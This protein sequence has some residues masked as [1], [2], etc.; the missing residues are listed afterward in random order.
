MSTAG[1]L[2]RVVQL[3]LRLR[4]R[5]INFGSKRL[6]V[7]IAV[8]AFFYAALHGISFPLL[9]LLERGI[10]AAWEAA[11]WL[12]VAVLAFIAA[13]SGLRFQRDDSALLLT[14]PI[15]N[16]TVLWARL[17]SLAGASI[18]PTA[19][20]VTPSL[21]MAVLMHGPHYLGCYVVLACVATAS[22]TAAFS[23][24]LLLGRWLGPRRVLILVRVVG[25]LIA[26]GVVLLGQLPRLMQQSEL[27]QASSRVP[28]LNEWPLLAQ[29]TAA[30]RADALALLVVVAATTTVAW[31][32]AH[33]CG[34]ALARGIQALQENSARCTARKTLITYRWSASLAAVTYRKE[35]RLFVRDPVL[36][37]QSF[38]SIA[39]I[40]PLV[41]V[42]RN[43]G[44]GVLAT[45]ACA[46]AQLGSMPL[47]TTAAAAEQCWDVIRASPTPETRLRIAKLLA[48]VTLPVALA[49]V[50]CLALAVLGCPWLALTG[51]CAGVIGAAAAGWLQ[52]TDIVPHRRGVVRR[53]T[54]DARLL[55]VLTS[56]ALAAPLIG[57]VAACAQNHLLLGGALIGVGVFGAGCVFGLCQITAA[58]EEKFEAL[59]AEPTAK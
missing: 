22:A 51:F 54:D 14:A 9:H 23:L 50:L 19:F 6:F 15:P 7:T 44:V 12:L 43:M 26:M 5:E 31:L 8:F 37:V 49:A 4:L 45:L 29:L 40:L 18:I 28:P 39:P 38:V 33:F 17:V 21:N 25:A 34:D 1:F 46:I 16:R 48:G 55:R 47:V 2:W 53:K 35:L 58:T 13:F 41:I 36:L 24:A 32:V 56:L 20:L 27:A 10:P 3:D 30:G 57:G 11:G 59:R 42:S 52:V